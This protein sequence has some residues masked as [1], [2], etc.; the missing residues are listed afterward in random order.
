MAVVCV[1]GASGFIGS[2]TV[3]QL[4]DRG[5]T[6]HGTV[7]DASN[8]EK[9]KHLT[10]LPGAQERLKLFSADLTSGPEP[11]EAA[12]AGTTVVMHMATAVSGTDGEK[13]IFMPGMAGL[14]AVLTA[15][16][17]HAA[18]VQ[19]L[20]LTS[21][22]SAVAPRPEPP[23]KSEVHWSDPD[24]QK[25]RGGWY[26][27]TKTMQEKRFWAWQDDHKSKATPGLKDIRAVAINPT[28]VLGPTLQTGVKTT[29]DWT[30]D[31]FKN[32]EGPDGRASNDSNSFI[33]VRDCAA[34]HVAAMENA[35]ASG[36]YM[37]ICGAPVPGQEGKA[38]Q[39]YHWND[40]F[41]I[42][43]EAYPDMPDVLP[44]EG[45]AIVPTR[46]D[47]T[48]MATLKPIEEMKAAKEMF[49][50]LVEHFKQQGAL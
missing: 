50:D 15:V 40:I 31:L 37:S 23:L 19:T 17:R 22:M 21:S 11:F 5:H 48:K 28:A 27:H 12:M 13:E 3:A 26:G 46:F 36:R 24:A 4:L 9:T 7:R 45:E 35:E 41:P 38:W 34:H 43:K 47:L 6:V 49:K 1:T 25:A 2:H 32:G 14:E 42:M 16:E 10:D 39:S 30:L 20:I 8:V 29:N 33:D 18:S 44:C